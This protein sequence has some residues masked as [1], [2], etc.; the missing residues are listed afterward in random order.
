MKILLKFPIRARAEKFLRVLQMYKSTCSKPSSV[1][2][3]ISTD[4]DDESITPDFIS[5]A[6]NIFPFA[7]LHQN[8]PNGKIAACNANLEMM[9]DDVEIIVLASDDMIPQVMGWDE[10]LVEE[11]KKNYPNTDGVLFHNEGYLGKTLNCMV[12]IG[13]EYFRRFGY[14]Y[15]PSYKSLWCDNE[16]QKVADQLGRQ[17]YFELVLFKH[18]H[19]FRNPSFP[20]DDLLKHNETFYREDQKNFIKRESLGFP[21]I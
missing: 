17:T 19:H 8:Q 6:L 18:N 5:K 13:I 4:V 9:D 15:H 3:I 16:F 12:I 7:T 2:V 10:I 14:L 21:I 20:S 11:M 1:Q